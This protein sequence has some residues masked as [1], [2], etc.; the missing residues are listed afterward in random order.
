MKF[1]GVETFRGLVEG[2]PKQIIEL[3][4]KA[5]LVYLRTKKKISYIDYIFVSICY[6]EILLCEY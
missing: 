2:K 3:D 1:L 6:K 5:Y 4:I